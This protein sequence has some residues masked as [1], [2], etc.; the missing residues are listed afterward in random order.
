MAETVTPGRMAPLSSVTCPVI[1]A[2]IPPCAAN[3]SAAKEDRLK[4]ANT[5]NVMSRRE[6]F[7]LGRIDYLLRGTVACLSN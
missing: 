1:V 6:T 7:Q 2:A 3:E 4:T 5:V